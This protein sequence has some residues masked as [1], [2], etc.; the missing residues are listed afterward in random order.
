MKY[1]SAYDAVHAFVSEMNAIPRGMIEKLMECDIYGWHEVTMP[2]IGNRVYV[3]GNECAGE[4]VN[5]LPNADTYLV[6]LDDDD[7][8]ATEV[9]LDDFEVI[10]DDAL[11][12][13]GTMWS[14]GDTLDDEWLEEDN[15]IQ[16]MSGC[17]FRIYYHEEWGYF[18]GIDG[19]G[20]DFYESHWMPLYK[21]RGL[22]W[23][24]EVYNE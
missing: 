8:T 24:Q 5:M 13:W 12:M 16:K 10:R 17:G 9:G 7:G 2:S 19:A 23:H 11:P 1:D 3:F 20:Y 15:G 22:K 21:V 18:F 14:F 4:I 6:N